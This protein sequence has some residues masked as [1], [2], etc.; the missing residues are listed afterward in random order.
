MKL[1]HR[2]EKE[3]C[4]ISVVGNIALNDT[5]ELET[6]IRPFISHTKVKQIILNCKNVEIID[7][8]G[9][10][11]LAAILKDL[12][13]EKK[14]FLLCHLNSATYGILESLQLHKIIRVKS[15][16]E[17]ALAEFN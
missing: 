13:D 12:E 4:V 17:E 5:S 6:Y 16:E 2:I 1:F 10:G 9:V 3:T 7:S 15:T 8:R 11:L 14:S